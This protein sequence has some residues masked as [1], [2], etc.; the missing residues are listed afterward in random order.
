[1]KHSPYIKIGLT[2]GIGAGKSTAAARFR[3]L[4]ALVLDADAIAR[5][6]LEPGG[7]CYLA[8]ADA[9]GEEI[10]L[11]DGKIDRKALAKIVFA[12]EEKR[13]LLNELVHPHV[14]EA[15]F[16]RAEADLGKQGGIAVFEVPL[17]FESGMHERMDA[18]V[19]VTADE[20]TRLER[21]CRRDGATRESAISRIRAQ[22]PDEQKRLLANYVL[23]NNGSVAE[24][25][26][27]IDRVYNTLLE[28][29]HAK[30]DRA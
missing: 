3:A 26:E 6:A 12:S 16:S 14:I 29:L 2:G 30:N 7:A 5:A 28:E 23:E 17:L 24:L 4:G 22:M 15:M 11:P 18:N 27:Q 8:V 25:N 9:F 20:E 10:L 13:A 1:M 19:L 21:V